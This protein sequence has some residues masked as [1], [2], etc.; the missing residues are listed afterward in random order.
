MSES[1][2]QV[3]R[4]HFILG[5]LNYLPVGLIN[6]PGHI[7]KNFLNYL[8][9]GVNPRHIDNMVFEQNKLHEPNDSKRIHIYRSCLAVA[10]GYAN[11]NPNIE[12]PDTEFTIAGG[13]YMDYLKQTGTQDAFFDEALREF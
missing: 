1:I 12:P 10:Y 13:L 6:H 2:N 7:D 5:R 11:L 8:F 9:R 3:K 4:K